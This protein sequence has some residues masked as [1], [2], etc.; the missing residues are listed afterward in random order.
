MRNKI[1]LSLSFT[2]FILS[3]SA[4]SSQPPALVSHYDDESHSVALSHKTTKEIAPQIILQG[5]KYQFEKN[6]LSDIQHELGGIIHHTPRTEWI[7][8]YSR[9]ERQTWWF[10]SNKEMHH[11]DLSGIAI[12][13]SRSSQY[14]TDTDKPL[15]VIYSV[16]G[17]G[18]QRQTVLR[19]FDIPSDADG[20]I[21]FYH[22]H[23][24]NKEVTQLNGLQ[25][26]FTGDKVTEILFSQVTTM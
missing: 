15:S 1:T 20:N 4:I 23:A 22:E 14:C 9:G 16:P 12:S 2:S 21:S 8:F 13:Q 5:H 3:F 25:Y 26:Y 18:A 6:T 7:C 24:L 10:L 11:G 17:P 19:Y